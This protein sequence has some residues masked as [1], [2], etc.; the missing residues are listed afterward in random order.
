M[1][2]AKGL[3]VAF[4]VAALMVTGCERVPTLKLVNN[5]PLSASFEI[6][7]VPV[8]I[9]VEPNGSSPAAPHPVGTVTVKARTLLAEVTKTCNLVQGSQTKVTLTRPGLGQLQLDCV[10]V[11]NED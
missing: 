9:T 6:G 8:P 10:I 3:L 4:A 2:R 5:T 11:P 7:G 1:W